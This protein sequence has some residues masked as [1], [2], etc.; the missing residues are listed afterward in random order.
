MARFYLSFETMKLITGS[1]E[2]SGLHELLTIIS[3]AQELSCKC[4]PNISCI[5]KIRS[6]KLLQEAPHSELLI[7]LLER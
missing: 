1:D 6:R 5:G 7:S 4:H 2:R 3:N